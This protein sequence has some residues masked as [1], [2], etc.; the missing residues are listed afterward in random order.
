MVW[1][2]EA[3]KTVV[4]VGLNGALWGLSYTPALAGLDFALFQNALAGAN[5][6]ALL[7]RGRLPPPTPPSPA[8]ALSVRL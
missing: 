5:V 2:C 4:G 6:A 1:A 8:P 3:V 7:L